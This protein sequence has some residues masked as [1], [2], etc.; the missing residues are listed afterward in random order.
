MAN[1]RTV[2]IITVR[3]ISAIVVIFVGIPAA[4]FLLGY[5]MSPKDLRVDEGKMFAFIVS[6]PLLVVIAGYALFYCV[7][8]ILKPFNTQIRSK[9]VLS[10]D[11]LENRLAQAMAEIGFFVEPRSQIGD[12]FTFMGSGRARLVATKSHDGIVV[13]GSSYL[14][15]RLIAKLGAAQQVA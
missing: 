6:I 2:P 12:T 4:G 13:V 5:S 15:D 8:V 14:V 9:I 10:Q 7:A 3:W 11:D 1:Q